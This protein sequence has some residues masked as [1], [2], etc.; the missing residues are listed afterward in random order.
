[1]HHETVQQPAKD[2][3]NCKNEKH[4]QRAGH[5]ERPE[6]K[7]YFGNRDILDYE[8][9]GKTG[10]NQAHHKFK[11]HFFSLLPVKVPRNRC[12]EFEQEACR[13]VKEGGLIP[14]RPYL[15]GRRGFRR[16]DKERLIEPVWPLY[17]V[18]PQDIEGRKAK[19][20]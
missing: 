9:H 15:R 6:Q 4:Q 7:S 20:P 16:E 17:V 19:A 13:L 3:A 1:M 10:K 8:E 5:G 18:V 2:N 11:I 14:R 12:I